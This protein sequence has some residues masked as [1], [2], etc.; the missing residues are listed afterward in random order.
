MEIYENHT[1]KNSSSLKQP[2]IYF[3]L[4]S[5][6]FSEHFI[7]ALRK[8]SNSFKINNQP[9]Q[10]N[11]KI[12]DG[13]TLEILKNPYPASAVQPCDGELDVIY[14][15]DDYLV[16]NKPHLLACIPTR[17]HYQ[18]NLGGRI[19][20]YMQE[21]DH[22]FVLRIINRL[23]KDTAGIVIV[24]KSTSAYNKLAAIDKTYFALC[25]GVF[26]KKQF[27]I[28]KPILTINENGINQMKRVVSKS[29]KHS[30]THATIEKE[31]ATHSLVRL[32]LETGRTHQIRVHLS[33]IGHSLIGDHIY[34][35]TSESENHTFL[36][37]K[38]VSFTNPQTGKQINLNV[39]FPSEWSKYLP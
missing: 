35:S 29:G 17:S 16:V 30:I 28:D 37:L 38:E 14:E 36:T 15:D 19:M 23:D 5:M 3:W 18:D 26:N 24:A 32:K 25:H 7:K 10:I 2:T 6:G 12:L 4:K 11:S 13:D 33:S 22:N 27:T 39:P 20:K 31:F 21:R 9:C 1:I 34:S 8:N